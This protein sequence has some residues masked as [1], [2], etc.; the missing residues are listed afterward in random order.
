M[1][2]IVKEIAQ[3][4]GDIKETVA[5]QNNPTIILAQ[6]GQVIGTANIP[7]D[8]KGEMIARLKQLRRADQ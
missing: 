1:Q 2:P 4:Q 8:E 3:I 6:I 5:I 7:E